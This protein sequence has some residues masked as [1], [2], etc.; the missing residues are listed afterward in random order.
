MTNLRGA[1][2]SSL[3][4]RPRRPSDSLVPLFAAEAVDLDM[5]AA[6][7]LVVREAIVR[8][9]AS[10]RSP[11]HRLGRCVCRRR[12]RSGVATRR[13]SCTAGEPTAA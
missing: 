11:P 10:H 9:A 8:R 6:G 4:R 13:G 7:P 5:S 2:P 3:V 1:V 12:R